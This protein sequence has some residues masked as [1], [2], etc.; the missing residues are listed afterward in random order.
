MAITQGAVGPTALERS[1]GTGGEVFP[2]C[3]GS[4][5]SLCANDGPQLRE[6]Q[7]VV[8]V[9]HGSN[10]VPSSAAPCLGE[11]FHFALW[12]ELADAGKVKDPALINEM[13]QGL[14]IVGPVT[15]SGRWPFLIGP[16]IGV[17]LS[18]ID[19]RAM[20]GRRRDTV[21]VRQRRDRSSRLLSS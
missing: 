1:L 16:M 4:A 9:A 3:I 7:K 12:R 13:L 14:S 18:A 15:R 17:P 11:L 5:F 19:A 2:L 21:T 6:V 10:F 8:E 20:S